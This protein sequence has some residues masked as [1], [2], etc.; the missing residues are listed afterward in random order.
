M[1]YDFVTNRKKLFNPLFYKI[2]KVNTRILV[3]FG[4]SGSG[5]SVSQHQLELLLQ[6]KSTTNY[7]TLFIRKYGTDIYDSCYKLLESLAKKYSIYD[8]FEWV[9][10]NSKRQI[11]NRKTGHRILFKGIDDSEK[12]KSIVGIK[13]IVVE[14]S[15]Q[16]EF[17]DFL[18]LNRRARGMEGIQITLLLNPVSQNHWIKTKLIEG[19]AY[20]GRVTVI[21]STY[22][23]NKFLTKDDVIELESLQLVDKYHYD[24]YCLG[25]WGVEDPN[26]IFAKD[27]K[28]DIHF[29][30]PFIE[31]YKPEIPIVYLSWDFNIDNTC[32]AIQNDEWE[33]EINY[34]KEYHIKGYDIYML[35]EL[36]THDFQGHQFIINGDASGHGGNALT[37]ENASAYEIIKTIFNLIWEMFAVPKANP[38]HKSARLLT[39]IIFKHFKINISEEC[40]ELDND[41]RNV[42]IDDKGSLDPYKAKHPERSHWLQP[43]Y[44]HLFAHHSDKLTRFKIKGQNGLEEKE[45]N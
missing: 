42:E 15:N 3:N 4:G 10:S 16:L 29:G 11:T 37:Q 9:Y 5:K 20:K 24:V 39:N 43:F 22:K 36:I 21:H 23:D 6:L 7:D 41:L 25:E 32:L 38:R 8:E 34:L 44:Y 14:E 35:S 31:L 18:E 26:K 17:K 27:Y 19:E 45:Q 13:R 28:K 12:I 30:K 40:K 2:R 1:K 33:D